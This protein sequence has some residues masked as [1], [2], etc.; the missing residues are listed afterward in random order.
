[1]YSFSGVTFLLAL[2]SDLKTLRFAQSLPT[3]ARVQHWDLQ[4]QGKQ[5]GYHGLSGAIELWPAD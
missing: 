1:M 5:S 2:A 4:E 3:N